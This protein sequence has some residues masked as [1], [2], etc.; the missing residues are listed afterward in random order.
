MKNFSK[1]LL[2]VLSL[3]LIFTAFAVTA[4]AN[5]EENRAPA[6]ILE[7]DFENFDYK[8]TIADDEKKVGKWTV[9]EADN[10]NKY[11][12]GEYSTDKGEAS[13]TNNWDISFS[14]N[15]SMSN[16]G[17]EV[18]DTTV[19][20]IQ[21]YPI[22]ACDFDVMSPTGSYLYGTYLRPDLYGGDTDGRITQ[23]E[24]LRYQNMKLTAEPYVWSHVTVIVQY[25]G[26]GFFDYI[27]YVNGKEVSNTRKD[28]S[29]LVL[30][31][32]KNLLYDNIRFGY[33]SNYPCMD[34]E[35]DGTDAE[36]KTCIDN[37]KYTYYPTGYSVADVVS[38]VYKSD[39]ELPYGK[40]VA[41]LTD[42]E[43]G[44][45]TNYD[46]VA[47]AILN[48]QENDLVTLL[49]DANGTYAITKKINVETSGYAFDYEA[50]E[51]APESTEGTLL[52]FVSLSDKYDGVFT[53]SNVEEP[54]YFKGYQEFETKVL[55]AIAGAASGVKYEIVL[56]NDL[57]YYQ[58]FVLNKTYIDLTI[59]LNGN[60]L[61]RIDLYGNVYK[62]DGTGND[63]AETATTT[64]DAVFT[65][66]TNNV[67]RYLKLNVISS[68]S[69][70][71]FK[72]VSVNGTA[73]Y[74]A[75]GKLES[76]TAST[77]K[78]AQFIKGGYVQDATFK[79][80]GFDLYADNLIYLSDNRNKAD[81]TVNNCK[82]YKILGA[83]NKLSFISDGKPYNR[84]FISIQSNG[85]NKVTFNN[86]LF[87]FP[88]GVINDRSD[89]NLI[90]CWDG[91]NAG[92][93]KF[94]FN[95]CDI[96]SEATGS[97]FGIRVTNKSVVTFN[98]CRLSNVFQADGNNLPVV[99]GSGNVLVDNLLLDGGAQ[100][101]DGSTAIDINSVKVISLP[102][103]DSKVAFSAEKGL[104][105][106]LEFEERTLSFIKKTG[107]EENLVKIEWVGITGEKLATTDDFKDTV[108]AVPAEITKVPTGNGYT[109][110]T[111]PIWL[112]EN[113]EAD[114]TITD[115]NTSFKAALSE[116]PQYVSNVEEVL[117][118]MSYYDMIGYVIYVPVVDGVEITKLGAYTPGSPVFRIVKIEG[119]EYYASV[120]DWRGVT[121]A[122]YDSNGPIEFT[123]HGTS[124]KVNVKLSIQRYASALFDS[125][126]GAQQCE[127]DA[128]LKLMAYVEQVRRFASGEATYESDQTLFDNFFGTYY[129]TEN[130]DA[131]PENAQNPQQVHEIEVG[132][133][134]DK[135]VSSLQYALHD[136]GRFSFGLTFEEGYTNYTAQLVDI[137]FS[138]KVVATKDEEGN[139]LSYTY[140]TRDKAFE[141][142]LKEFV[143]NIK[144]ENGE[145]VAT[146]NYNLAT[147]V[148][149][150]NTEPVKDLAASMYTFGEAIKEVRAYIGTL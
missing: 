138:K 126:S 118:N 9:Y 41:T 14:A 98:G 83:N 97:N 116:K 20:G 113:G 17:K 86:S 42:S 59:D 34:S 12:V 121:D 137:G 6:C 127:K 104:L 29:S 4:L 56:Y 131:R 136:S 130:P 48:A 13:G 150:M 52:K 51:Y 18:I 93:T 8:A 84:G 3:A 32:D 106:D 22:F 145:I 92:S 115:A 54:Y 81:L 100:L 11:V 53:S 85:S 62:D 19:Y 103:K 26:N 108:A 28:Y 148:A 149:A 35:N 109:A 15:W 24:V 144:N 75:N 119:K 94:T 55:E 96:I 60:T 30:D 61:T 90:S 57:E 107:V 23:G 99:L 45:V 36:K 128:I 124:F 122:I 89:Y 50:T 68:K 27:I 63:V 25:A 69:G 58:T 31:S 79:L 112:N 1:I 129:N 132:G 140:F 117:F 82:F 114:L 71:E 125:A 39:Y 120:A 72:T 43:T 134:F 76:Y 73:Y 105:F 123:A 143:I 37:M 78:A 110:T 91:S 21:K 67:A 88:S 77:V 66:P 44:A 70:A 38:Y 133:E 64:S 87:F 2:L 40:T 135:Y 139:A 102:K 7:L 80:E 49:E 142:L 65:I 74:D 46:S 111:N 141:I 33:V 16:L 95:D 146:Q 47:E 10:G 101:L 147:Y 5:E